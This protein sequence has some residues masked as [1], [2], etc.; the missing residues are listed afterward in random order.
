[1]TSSRNAHTN[2]IPA[3]RLRLLACLAACVVFLAAGVAL[4]PYA[5]IQND[6][7][8]FA[9]PLFQPADAHFWLSILRHRVP[10]MQMT[11]LGDLKAWI[12]FPIFALWKPS[13]ASI[14]VPMLLVGG[15]SIWLFYKLLDS[16]LG[17]RTAVVGALLL[18]TDTIYLLTICFDWGP[19]ALQHLLMLAGLLLLVWFQRDG[20]VAALAGGWACFGLAMWDKAIFSWALG[21][22]LVAVVVVFPRELRRAATLRNVLVATLAFAAGAAPFILYNVRTRLET[23][24]GNASFSTEDFGQKVQVFRTTLNGSSLF[25]YLV[26]DDW[27]DQPKHAVTA[28]ERDSTGLT[29]YFGERRS[30]YLPAALL[31]GLLMA[32]LWW[33]NRAVRRAI[34]FSLVFM[35][36][37]WAQMLITRT[38]GGAAHHVVLLWPFPHLIAA[39]TITEAAGRARRFSPV[40]LAATVTVLVAQNLLVTNQYMAQFVRDGAA[41]PWTDAIYPL[42]RSLEGTTAAEIWVTDWGML[43][44]LRLLD[45]GRLPLR[46]GDGPLNKPQP[47]DNDRMQV[48]EMLET[49]NSL[50]VG[51]VLKQETF[52]GVGTHLAAMAAQLGYR[53]V[54][55]RT[56]L[57]SNGRPI[58]EISRYVRAAR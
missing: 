16:T 45:R 44:S 34:L 56:V 19:V 33:P 22:L 28:L 48:R 20:R 36:V 42:A 24:R 32:P 54:L 40:I 18:A 52:A 6:E 3:G 1:M 30:N 53:K 31:I 11:Y 47:D 8:L 7:A 14:R 23:F 4:L 17:G 5:G 35:A 41:G 29:R 51:H 25:G 49:P 46:T 58:F 2:P 50:F 9:S 10:L 57:D 13:P 55:L 15:V 21:G 39:A 37:A 38:A 27:I 26:Y 43:N 12:Y